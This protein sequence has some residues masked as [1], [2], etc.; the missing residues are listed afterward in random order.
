MKTN[1]R[2]FLL[3]ALGASSAMAQTVLGPTAYLS[4][5]DSPFAALSVNGYFHFENFEDGLFNVPGVNADNGAVFGPAGL[6]D[7]VDG[8]DGSIDGLG[9]AG[10]SFFN[11]SGSVTFTFNSVTLGALPT[12]VGLVWTDGGNPTFTAYD[13]GNNL[14]GTVSGATADGSNSGT[15]A[16]DRFYGFIYA[17]GIASIAMTASTWEVDHLQFGTLAAVPEPATWAGLTGAAAFAAV[18]LR[19]RRSP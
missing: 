2:I 1:L 6:A 10:R 3:L 16:E 11:T 4:Y 13:A 15:T 18:A 7:S 9:Q 19:R 8:D 5:S 12:H 14:L 17:G